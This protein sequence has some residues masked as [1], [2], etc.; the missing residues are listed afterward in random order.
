MHSLSK[1]KINLAEIELNGD[2]LIAASGSIQIGRDGVCSIILTPN[3]NGGGE[4][5]TSLRRHPRS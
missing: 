1:K 3:L 5:L 4:A 2:K